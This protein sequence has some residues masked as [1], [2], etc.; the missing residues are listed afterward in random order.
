[1]KLSEIHALLMKHG[2]KTTAEIDRFD[3]KR[4]AGA[5]IGVDLMLSN[6]TV[7]YLPVEES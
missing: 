2:H 6:G 3:F 4:A 1:M 5:I 7:T